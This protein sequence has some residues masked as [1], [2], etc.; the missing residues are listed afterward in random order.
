MRHHPGKFLTRKY[1]TLTGILLGIFTLAAVSQAAGLRAHHNLQ[2]EVFPAANKLTGLDHITIKSAAARVL[3]FHI[4]ERVS[5][6]KVAVNKKPRDF[7]FE[8]GRLKL[9]LEPHEQ[10]SH[11]LVTIS[12][13]GL[14]DDP[15]P[16]RPL[17]ADN[18]GYGVTATISEKGSFL[19]AGAGWYPELAGSRATYRLKVLAPAGLIAVTAGRSLG[20]KTDQGQTASTWEVDYPGEG[21]SLSVA[22]YVVTEKSVGRVTAA[23]YLLTPNQHLAQSYLE[24]TAGY[25]GLFSDLFGPYPFDKFAVVENFFPT[26][27]G[28]PSYTLMG[29]SVLRLPFIIHTSLGHEIAHCWWGNGVYVDYAAGNWSEALTTYVAD[30]LFKEM[31]SKQAALDYRRQWLRNFSTLVRPQNDFPLDRFMS[32]YNPVSKVIGYDKGAMVF[33]M[34]R[35][36]LGEEGFWNALRDIYRNRLFKKTSW[37][38]LQRAF[39]A[40][41]QRSLKVFF[42][43]WLHRKSAPRFFMDGVQLNHS[44]GVWKVSGQIVQKDPRSVFSIPLVLEAGQERIIRE[45]ELS[46]E[47]T[48]FEMISRERPR[49]LSA[50]P[51][52]DTMRLLYASEIPPAVN[53]IKGAAAVRI[54]LSNQL[55]ADLKKAAETLALSLGLK[56]FEFISEGE[57]RRSQLIE[58]D[59][60]LVGQPG[61]IDLLQKMPDQVA[62]DPGSFTLNST[63][64]N[65]PSDAFFGVFHH[66]FNDNRTAALFIPS[67][68]R[69]ADSVARKITHYGKYSYL[70]FQQGK[71]KVK[72]IWQAGKSPLVVE[73]K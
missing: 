38:D 48:A 57:V 68:K 62:L 27:F 70:V 1:L 42:D 44:D 32:R 10:S 11:L 72:G 65:K 26:G 2:I 19:L 50:D 45:I 31:K 53:N 55:P 5:P 41:G 69:F 63:V 47:A 9:A 59:I 34:L 39:E 21:L 58:N 56:N 28:F 6:L 13:A 7:D 64:Y 73:W 54:V 29:G 17:N 23:T 25:I 46:G 15:V 37:S 43:Q 14:F 52:Y 30:Y 16:V 61:Q 67:S 51:A 3:E 4:S 35:R 49:R 18:P 66:P 60:L 40:R 71:N 24:A 20:H 8:N 36:Q 33:H 12:Y 22:R